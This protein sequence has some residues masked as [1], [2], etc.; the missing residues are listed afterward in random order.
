MPVLSYADLLSMRCFC[1]FSTVSNSRSSSSNDENL[2]LNF[3][4]EEK[5]SSSA[6]E[7]IDFVRLTLSNL[8][9][10]TPPVQKLANCLDQVGTTRE[11]IAKWMR[12]FKK[13]S[14]K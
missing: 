2:H 11:E 4:V 3:S 14:K 6:R 10:I 5:G 1:I 7:T 13:L 8:S 12:G 9:Y